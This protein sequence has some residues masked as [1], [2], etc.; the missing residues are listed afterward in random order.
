MTSTEVDVTTPAHVPA[1][2]EQAVA[3][4]P[5][6]KT[7]SVS[8]PSFKLGTVLRVVGIVLATAALVSAGWLLWGP[9]NPIPEGMGA[10]KVPGGTLTV[11]RDTGNGQFQAYANPQYLTSTLTPSATWSCL[12]GKGYSEVPASFGINATI[13]IVDSNDYFVCN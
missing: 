11:N 6:R 4:A 5:N 10:Y 13:M 9:H 2:V 7:L 3:L 1:S 12:K 8:V